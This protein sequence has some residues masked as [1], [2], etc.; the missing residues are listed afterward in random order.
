MKI[1]AKRKQVEENNLPAKL[2]DNKIKDL[3]IIKSMVI[4][5]YE[6]RFRF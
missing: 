6:P 4:N 5:I 1:V 2:V 3:K